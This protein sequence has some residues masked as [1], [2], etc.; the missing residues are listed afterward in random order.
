M[1]GARY[2]TAACISANM[3][4]KCVGVL[5]RGLQTDLVDGHEDDVAIPGYQ[6][7]HGWCGRISLR[8]LLGP[9]Y[10]KPS[11]Y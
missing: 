3:S 1:P 6:V 2:A 8:M 10:L 11:L 7:G 4:V 5:D 9:S